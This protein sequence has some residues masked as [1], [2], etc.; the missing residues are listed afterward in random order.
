VA[1]EK[2]KKAEPPALIYDKAA[3]LL[4]RLDHAHTKVG[5]VV[6]ALLFEDGR[7]FVSLSP[8]TYRINVKVER[9]S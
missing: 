4:I 2:R 9:I 8:G 6:S 7:A 1:K 5:T 3:E